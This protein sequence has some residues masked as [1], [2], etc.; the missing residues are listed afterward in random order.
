MNGESKLHECPVGF[1]FNSHFNVCQRGSTPCTRIDCSRATAVNPFIVYASNPAYYAMCVNRGNGQIETYMFKCPR[2]EVFDTSIKSCRF[3]CDAKGNFQ[4]PANC[5]EYFNCNSAS[6]S[7]RP[8]TLSCPKDFVFDGSRCN[9][10]PGS[11]KYP[12]ADSE[13]DE[14]NE[15]DQVIEAAVTTTTSLPEAF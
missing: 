9:S 4:N 5:T 8:T 13:E 1:V 3:N 10:D 12:P 14:G 7:T 2:S 15:G 11:C 6:A